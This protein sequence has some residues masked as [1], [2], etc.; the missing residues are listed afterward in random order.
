MVMRY[1]CL[2]P[3]NLQG[4]NAFCSLISED[5]TL[6]LLLSRAFCTDSVN[7]WFLVTSRSLSFEG[8]VAT[9]R[10]W[11]HLAISPR[12]FCSCSRDEGPDVHTLAYLDLST[13]NLVT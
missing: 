5:M 3:T 13:H 12:Y 11:C 6:G 2:Y 8:V 10:R 9:F 7:H 4:T 1:V